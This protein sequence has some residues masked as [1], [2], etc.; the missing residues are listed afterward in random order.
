MLSLPKGTIKYFSG[1][2]TENLE[3][4]CVC[5]CVCV[6][7]HACMYVL[8]AQSC[9]TLCDPMNCSLPGSSV[10]GIF[11]A[12]ILEWAAIPSLQGIFPTQGS[13]P[14]LPHGRQILY[15]L[16]HQRSPRIINMECSFIS[17]LGRTKTMHI[18]L[19]L[20]MTVVAAERTW[21]FLWNERETEKQRRHQDS[22]QNKVTMR[23]P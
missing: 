8:V 19:C 14:G 21:N 23:C 11:Q 13:N 3:H 15:C 1:F 16:S 4:V 10:H 2:R 18:F 5:V 12:R 17:A 20:Y 22:V 7:T 9:P 6:C